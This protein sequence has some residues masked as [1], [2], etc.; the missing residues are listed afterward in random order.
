[1]KKKF[2]LIASHSESLLNFRGQLMQDL[3]SA[4]LEVHVASPDLNERSQIRKKLEDHNIIVHEISLKRTGMNPIT[5]LRTIYQIYKLMLSLKPF[6]FLAYTHKPVIYGNLAAILAR[7]PKRFSLITGLGYTFQSEKKWL[8]FIVKILYRISLLG[9]DKIFFQNPDNEAEFIKLKIIKADKNQSILVN[10]SGIDIDKFKLTP[11]PKDIKFLLISRL[12]FDKG[13]LEYFEAVSTIKKLYPK[14]VFG[15]VGWFDENPNSISEKALMEY[16]KTGDIEFH[17]RLDDVR[18]V[19]ANSS[20]YVLPSYSE[21]TP[22]TVLE[23]MSMG[24]PIITTDAPGC[25]ETVIN[26]KNGFLV[27]VKNSDYLVSSMIRFI[28]EPN[29]ITTM[30]TESRKI[31]EEKYDVK[32]VN[33]IMLAG[34]EIDLKN[35]N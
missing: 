5:D 32:K 15:L 17:G 10:G 35:I 22:R 9:S 24:R 27:P 7:I 34:M 13:I 6:Y 3:L 16:I 2:L 33:S 8:N 30:G 26:N 14:V 18:P 23:A 20:V 11:L 4:N 25:R 1:M 19:I 12:L 28:E 31:A 21:G 29:L